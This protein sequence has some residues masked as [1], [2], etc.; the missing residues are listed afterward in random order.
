MVCFLAIGALQS[1]AG[2]SQC[3]ARSAEPPALP[4][5]RTDFDP[6]EGMFKACR[7]DASLSPSNLRV[8]G[9]WRSK[10]DSAEESITLVTQLTVERRVPMPARASLCGGA[11]CIDSSASADLLSHHT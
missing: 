8:L 9:S 7:S 10:K 4:V 5:H 1:Y 11:R 3:V 6:R 2:Q